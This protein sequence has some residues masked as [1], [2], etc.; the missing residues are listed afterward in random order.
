[1]SSHR[2]T[3]LALA[4]MLVALSSLVPPELEAQ[5]A[6]SI[7]ASGTR[8]LLCDATTDAV[9][10]HELVLRWRRGDRA[11]ARRVL[12]RVASLRPDCRLLDALRAAAALHVDP[13]LVLELS[14]AEIAGFARMPAP[15]GEMSA[16][17][18]GLGVAGLVLGAVAY[19]TTSTGASASSCDHVSFA[20]SCDAT[21]RTALLTT[22][23]LSGAV[24]LALTIA[25]IALRVE[26]GSARHRWVVGVFAL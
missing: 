2:T 20:A 23:V 3:T 22:G 12:E 6:A 13:G 25:A 8:T 18:H 19:A 17:S 11:G 16:L 10:R 26:V 21:P 1:M 24:A 4:S 5:E 15:I 14:E 9:H 7:D